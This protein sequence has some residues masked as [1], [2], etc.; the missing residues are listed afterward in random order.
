MVVTIDDYSESERSYRIRQT[1]S[2]ASQATLSPQRRSETREG[3][4]VRLEVCYSP[5]RVGPSISW[6]HRT[7]PMNG[8]IGSNYVRLA[9]NNGDVHTQL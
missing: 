5:E 1:S 7:L 6:L 4:G 3:V 9:R 2:T 8:L